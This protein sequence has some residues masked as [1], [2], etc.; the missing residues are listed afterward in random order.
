MERPLA[1]ASVPPGGGLGV[2]ALRKATCAIVGLGLLG[3]AFAFVAPRTPPGPRPEFAKHIVRRPAW[4]TGLEGAPPEVREFLGRVLERLPEGGANV[5]DYRF[6]HW[7]HAGKPTREAVGIKAIPGLDPERLVASILDVDGYV[8]RIPHVEACRSVPGPAPASP[9]ALR[10][11]QAIRV[12]GIATVQQ[13]LALVD[14]GTV[15]GYRLVYWSLLP[16][17]TRALDPSRGARSA[18]SVGAWLAAPGV[19]GYALSTWP[20]RGDVNALQWA[21]LTS[22]ADGLAQSVVEGSIDAMAAGPADRDEA[23]DRGR[24]AEAAD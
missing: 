7:E 8:G 2:T 15:R 20:R 23:G 3:G 19:A 18:F 1:E 16:D 14:A 6:E 4:P 22:G 24:A 21:S 5:T 9:G 12:P 10:C 11:Y 17:E 13:E